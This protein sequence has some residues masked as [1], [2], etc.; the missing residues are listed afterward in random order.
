[1]HMDYG[2]I[3]KRAWEI[4]WRYKI[5]WVFGF[6][7]GAAG[8]GSSGGSRYNSG[9]GSG[10]NN[11][12][13]TGSEQ[14]ALRWLEANLALI[15]IVGVILVLIGL[16]FWVLSV[17]AR[18]GLVHL[19]NEAAEGRPV[20]AGPGWSVGFHFWGRT[21]LIGFLLALPVLLVLIVAGVFSLPVILGAFASA[22]RGTGGAESGGIAALLGICGILAIVA[23]VLIPLGILLAVLY[24]LAVRHGV[25]DD[26]STGQAISAAWRD[27]RSRFKDVALTWLVLLVVGFAWGLVILVIVAIV[28]LPAIG[29]AVARA[30]AAAIVA[31]ILG[32]LVLMLP[33]AIYA[34]FGSSIWTLVSR[35]ITGRDLPAA[36][37]Y[38]PAPAYMPPAPGYA[39]QPPAYPPPAPQPPAPGEPSGWAPPPAPEPPAPTPPPPPPPAGPMPALGW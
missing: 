16:L 2:K 3:L 21:F 26:M 13:G 25:L 11:P 17:A 8:S 28:M 18:G 12:F 10:R 34:T 5:L 36:A 30:W 31:A 7:A 9:T 1:M 23:I 35:G 6:F 32:G 38:A 20:K 33:G 15:V 22:A 37:T 4:T 27:I 29:L 14:Q 39:P 24:E 19:V